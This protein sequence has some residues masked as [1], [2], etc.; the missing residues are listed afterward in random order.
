MVAVFKT[1]KQTTYIKI[2][3]IHTIIFMLYF[4]RYYS[5]PT[6]SSW[7]CKIHPLLN[8]VT[9]AAC[10]VMAWGLMYL[11]FDMTPGSQLAS[12][13]LLISSS[14][15]CGKIAEMLYLPPLLGM[16]LAGVVLRNSGHYDVDHNIFQP[17]IINL[18]FYVA[19]RPITI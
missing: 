13:V 9:S 8:A 6:T 18:R 3:V 11:F 10:V 19:R 5:G 15:A 14:W 17:H 4:A 2:F 16:L 7:T 12:V 1:H